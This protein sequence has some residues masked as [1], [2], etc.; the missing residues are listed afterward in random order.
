MFNHV[1]LHAT[2]SDSVGCLP[3]STKGYKGYKSRRKPILLNSLVVYSFS[4]FSQQIAECWEK[5]RLLLRLYL[6]SFLNSLTFTIAPKLPISF[7]VLLNKIYIPKVI[8]GASLFL[9]VLK[10]QSRKRSISD[11]SKPGNRYGWR[12]YKNKNAK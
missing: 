9:P 4:F 12:Q 2:D 10:I 8:Q 5:I 6:H 3:S 1:A 7:Y 11:W